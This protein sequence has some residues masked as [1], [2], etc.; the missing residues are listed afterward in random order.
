MTAPLLTTKLYVPPVRPAL[1]PRQRLIERMSEGLRG[2]CKLTL[3]SA[4]AGFGKTTLVSEWHASPA[5]R[6]VP[7]AWLSLDDDDNDPVRF[8]VY[9]IAA[10]QTV[11]AGVGAQ[12]Q[13]LLQSPQPPRAKPF[14]LQEFPDLPILAMFSQLDADTSTCALVQV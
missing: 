11:S 2:A 1:A 13:A 7:L 3:I 12:A 4:P 14:S 9:V 10:L 5:G 8:W 6:E